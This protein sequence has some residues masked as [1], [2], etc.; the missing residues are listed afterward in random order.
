MHMYKLLISK[1]LT[2]KLFS[3]QQYTHYIMMN[4]L[5]FLLKFEQRAHLKTVLLTWKTDSQAPLMTEQQF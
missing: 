5:Y 3:P 2:T 4:D 1:T